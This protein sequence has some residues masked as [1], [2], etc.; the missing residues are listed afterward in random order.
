MDKVKNNW[1]LKFI[2]PNTDFIRT[3]YDDGL[4][5]G[6]EY[7]EK[8][9]ILK[10]EELTL[11]KKYINATLP[12]LKQEGVFKQRPNGSIIKINDTSRKKRSLKIIGWSYEK[13]IAQ[14]L[15]SKDSYSELFYWYF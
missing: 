7:N 3:V 8:I 15:N 9:G 12:M 4:V 5:Y 6:K 10:S 2:F 14:I 1:I 13:T 11:I